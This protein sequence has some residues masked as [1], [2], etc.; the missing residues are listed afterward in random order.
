MKLSSVRIGI[1]IPGLSEPG[2]QL[3][4]STKAD[5]LLLPSGVVTVAYGPEGAR[6]TVVLS[7]SDWSH[8]VAAEVTPEPVQAPAPAPTTK[9]KRG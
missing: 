7:P 2:Q 4:D 5:I 6:K 9:A 8:G 3:V 1:R